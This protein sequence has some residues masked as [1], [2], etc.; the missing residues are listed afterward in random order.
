[1]HGWRWKNKPHL[2]E[3][4]HAIDTG[5]LPAAEVEH[6]TPDRRAGELAML[7]LRLSRGL[8]FA[9]FQ[10]RTGRDALTLFADVIAR[11]SGT[12]LLERTATAVHLT[13][14]GLAVADAVAAEFLATSPNC[15]T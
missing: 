7:M 12:G 13:D 4:E 10:D 8:V 9:E 6:L 14:T 1:V 15:S 2:G 3:W 11:Y 5:E